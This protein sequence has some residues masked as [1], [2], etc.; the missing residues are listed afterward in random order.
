LGGWLVFLRSFAG[1]NRYA[2]NNL[3]LPGS[4]LPNLLTAGETCD[5]PV[6]QWNEAGSKLLIPLYESRD[7]G[8]RL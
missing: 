3:V 2:F 4:G 6:V 8:N 1:T 5:A 7:E